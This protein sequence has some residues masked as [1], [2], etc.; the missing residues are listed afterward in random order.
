MRLGTRTQA[1]FRKEHCS[2]RSNSR[3]FRRDLG[4]KDNV[5]SSF[6]FTASNGRITGSNGDF[7]GKFYVGETV[8]VA[9][10]NLNNGNFIVTGLDGVNA[11]Y[12]TLDT[13]PK[14]EGPLTA[15]IRSA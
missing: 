13:A 8:N 14:D 7:T 9:G 3:S 15:T 6:T 1:G 5:T 11:A 4:L 10:T 12:L 2:G